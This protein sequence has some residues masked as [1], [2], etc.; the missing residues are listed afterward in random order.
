MACRAMFC[1]VDE[2]KRLTLWIIQNGMFVGHRYNLLIR[3]EDVSIHRSEYIG[4][5]R[6]HVVTSA[7]LDAEPLAC[8]K[9][10]RRVLMRPLCC[11]AGGDPL[12]RARGRCIQQVDLNGPGAGAAAMVSLPGFMAGFGAAAAD[13]SAGRIGTGWAMAEKET[14]ANTAAVVA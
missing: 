12:Y 8:L 7:H 3:N 5:R 11:R 1:H 9:T 13:S 4:R 2:S 14:L 10:A 6:F